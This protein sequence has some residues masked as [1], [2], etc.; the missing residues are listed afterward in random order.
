MPLSLSGFVRLHL[1]ISERRFQIPRSQSTLFHLESN[2]ICHCIV[3]RTKM[4]KKRP[5]VGPYL[6]KQG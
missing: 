4:K 1:V 2:N 6:K 5:G 3:K